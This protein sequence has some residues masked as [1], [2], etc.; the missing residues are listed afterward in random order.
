MTEKIR[1]SQADIA[2]INKAQLDRWHLAERI[3]TMA[4]AGQVHKI[5]G[6]PYIVHPGRVA[7]RLHTLENCAGSDAC[8]AAWL[9]DVL[10]DTAWTRQDMAACGVPNS[11]LD[12]VFF[13]TH[14][15]GENYLDY[16]LRLRRNPTAKA[17]KLA[18][19]Q[20]NMQEW[21]EEG[22]MKDKWRLAYWILSDGEYPPA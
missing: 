9:H 17:I 20:D 16:L 1:P 11:V 22:S 19:L 8:M 13:L 2:A 12:I 4:H 10:E 15:S 21:P 7:A 18:D 5:T 6:S 14:R 3:A